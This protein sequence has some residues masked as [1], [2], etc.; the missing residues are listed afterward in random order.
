VRLKKEVYMK[1][2]KSLGCIYFFFIP[3]LLSTTIYADVFVPSYQKKDGTQVQSHYRSNPDGN[4]N[5]NWNAKGNR[6]PYTG[7]IG[8]KSPEPSRGMFGN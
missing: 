1:M 5:N 6:N 3:Y 2:L 7:E 4:P 8:T